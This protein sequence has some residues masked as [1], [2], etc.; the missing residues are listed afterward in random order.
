VIVLGPKK[1]GQ[2]RESTV[3]P[4]PEGTQKEGAIKGVD[5]FAVR[6]T[7]GVEK[8]MP[9]RKKIP[10]ERKVSILRQRKGQM[11][12]HYILGV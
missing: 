2:E 7:I 4:R 11:M 1:I 6:Q 10:S 8:R 5:Q 9:A 12:G 3:K